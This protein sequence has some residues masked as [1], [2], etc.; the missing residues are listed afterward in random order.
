VRDGSADLEAPDGTDIYQSNMTAPMLRRPVTG[1]FVLEA[2]LET[3][4]KVFYQGAGL[5]LWNGPASYVRIERGFGGKAGTVGFEY[6]DGGVHIRVHGPLPSQHP[7]NTSATR[8]VLRMTRSGRTITGAW[9]PADQPGF[10]TLA[11]VKMTLPPTV[12]VGVAALNRAQFGAKPTPFH[13]R[14]DRIAVT[15]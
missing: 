2:A 3:S 13:A 1:D 9:R 10:A 7:I 8:L 14:F 15:C 6:K 11:T 12:Q 4:P 5:L